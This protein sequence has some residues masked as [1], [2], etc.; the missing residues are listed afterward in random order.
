MLILIFG[1]I[2]PKSLA[3]QN[4]EGVA[5]K[6]SRPIAAVVFVCRPFVW[7]FT[8]I[9]SFFIKI[10]GGDPDKA[11]PFITQEELKTLMDVGEEEGV[12]EGKEKEMIFNVFEFG[13]LQVKDI[14]AQRVD[15]I[16]ES[17]D[18]SYEEIL[19]G[20][21]EYQFS[22]IPVYEDNIDNIVGILYAKDLILL[23]DEDKKNFDVKKLMR[24]PYY[25]FEFKNIAD[26]FTEM[27]RTRNH[28]AIVLDEYGGT[29][30]I[31]TIE[32]LIEEIVGDIEDEYDEHQEDIKEIKENEYEVDGSTRLDDL[33]EII[34]VKI[35]S[36]EFD[37]I[38]GFVIG[39]LD[40]LPE[41]NEEILYENLKF[42]VE[43]I[44]KK[45]IKKIRIFVLDEV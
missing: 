22:R 35:E 17:I 7:L 2:T 42:I 25:T 36:D 21:Q 8:K 4:A 19:N 43:E 1:E 6:I 31:V 32:D 10:L 41:L 33:S 45:R 14:M 18:A 12:L 23:N 5:I 26:L 11:E 3:K 16:A 9:S 37:S 27:K 34:N 44:D 15:I 40:R 29:V 13:D 30:G 20:I 24:E 28:M 39:I 38:G